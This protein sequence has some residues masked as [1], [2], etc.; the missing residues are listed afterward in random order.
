MRLKY[1]NQIQAN[2]QIATNKKTSNIFDG[3]YKSVHRGKSMNFENLREYVINDDVK[4]IDWKASSRSGTL[5]VKQFIAEKKHNVMLIMDTGTKMAGD[6]SKNSAKKDIALYS[7]G[8]IGYIAI[9]NG[10]Y[11]SM[12]FNNQDSIDYKPF[13]YNLYNLEEYLT[14]YDKYAI[15]KNTL[16]ISETLKYLYKN[17]KRKMIIF[18]ITDMEGLDKLDAK[19]LKGLSELHDLLLINIDDAYLNSDNAYDINSNNYIPKLLTKDKQL[20]EIEKQIRKNLLD[21][22]RKK[23]KRCKIDMVTI[24]NKEEIPLKII[25]LLERHKYASNN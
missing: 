22:N 7:A 1:I 8:T 5:L 2:I 16:G 25:E 23:L 6:T 3:T 13:K 24:K 21:K 20:Y 4:D 18:V 14:A 19:V 12:M 9:H 17:I 11:I 15:S 10:D